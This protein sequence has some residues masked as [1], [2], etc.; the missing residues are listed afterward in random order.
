MKRRLLWLVVIMA[1]LTMVSYLA[2]RSNANNQVSAIAKSSEGTRLEQLNRAAVEKNKALLAELRD[3]PPDPSVTDDV[4]LGL[5]LRFISGN[6][7]EQQKNQVRQYMSDILG[8]KDR[9]DQDKLFEVGESYR[10]ESNQIQMQS[11]ATTR[12]YHPT[13]ST[14]TNTDRQTLRQLA[15]NKANLMRASKN[16]LRQ[17]LSDSTWASIQIALENRVKPRIKVSRHR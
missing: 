12:K 2:F 10:L 14:I 15:I 8:V 3:E 6:Q 13:H 11:E 5:V 7:N 1:T 4:A 17:Q 16:S 9:T